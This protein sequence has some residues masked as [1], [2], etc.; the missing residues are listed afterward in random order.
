MTA[1]VDMPSRRAKRLIESA[2]ELSTV[3]WNFSGIKNDCAL[4]MPALRRRF[5]W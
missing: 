3:T 4:P 2:S 5:R 1:E